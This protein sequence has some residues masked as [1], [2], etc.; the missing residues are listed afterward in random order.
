MRG[1]CPGGDRPG[2]HRAATR[3]SA[4]WSA[5]GAIAPSSL[6]KRPADRDSPDDGHGERGAAMVEFTF[7]AV[8]LLVPLAYV[9]VGAFTVQKAAFAV[10][11]AT[12]EAGRAFVTADSAAT[13]DARAHA[14]GALAMRDQ[15]LSLPDGA[16]KITCGDP[17][18]LL[19][20]NAVT[21]ELDYAVALPLVPHALGGR[22]LAAIR[23]HGHHVEVVDQF[24]AVP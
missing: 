23:V 15:G 21:V 2:H 16:L 20:G 24:R 14:A 9:V 5:V 7:L 8:L 4:L 17:E 1:T 3:S 12:R 6:H 22:P 13:A 18:C 11:A 19:P 10:T